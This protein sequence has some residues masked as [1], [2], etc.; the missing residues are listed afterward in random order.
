M[1]NIKTDDRPAIEGG[2][3]VRSVGF[4]PQ[5]DLGDDDIRELT[6]VIRSG[7]LSRLS[8]TKVKRFEQE[9]A[10]LNGVPYAQACTSG[11]AAVHVAVASLNMNPG[12][13]VITT[14]LSDMGSIIG[15]LMQNLVPTFA[16]IDPRTFVLDPVDVEKRLTDRTRAILAVHFFGQPCDMGA[17]GEIARAHNLYLIEDCAQALLSEY[18]GRKC[19]T[20]SDIAAFAFGGKHLTTGEGG[21]VITR[22]KDLFIRARLFADKAWPR[23]GGE[24]ASLFLGVNYRMSELTG[25]LGV[26]Q[27]RKVHGYV[28][29]KRKATARLASLMADL[30]GEGITLAYIPPENNPAL[31]LYPIRVDENKLGMRTADFVAAVEQE[32]VS[33]IF[34]YAILPMN[35]YPVLA[36][37]LTYGTSGCP[38][39]CA[40]YGRDI[41]YRS[42]S[43]PVVEQ[44]MKDTVVIQVNQSWTED[45]LNDIATAIRKVVRWQSKRNAGRL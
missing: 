43:F 11:T 26:S 39:K 38:F 3:P 37:Y 18:K 14:P 24:R 19:G 6:E 28:D 2:L 21:M 7:A 44:V 32:G 5:H 33:L 17:L 35:Q 9:F 36:D 10:A 41:D 34:P 15:V 13:E 23:L 27:M 42:M 25:A 1:A 29:R 16:D 45:D 22:K 8:G 30:D 31:W 40:A 20:L 12:D 4:G